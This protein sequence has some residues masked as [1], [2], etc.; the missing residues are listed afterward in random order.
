MRS[1]L[2][3]AWLAVLA[4]CTSSSPSSTSPPAAEVDAPTARLVAEILAVADQDRDG[5]LS[6]AEY[7]VVAFPDEPL[8]LYDSDQDGAL[9]EAEIAALLVTVNPAQLQSSRRHVPQQAPPEG[10]G[11]S[12]KGKGK[13][14][15]GK[16]KGKGGKGGRDDGEG[17]P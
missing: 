17:A 7:G 2:P 16:S 15:K 3:L 6:A 14:G 9:S 11:K 8:R 13:G 4:G 12:G 5:A 1:L 10:E